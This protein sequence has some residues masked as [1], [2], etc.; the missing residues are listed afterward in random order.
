MNIERYQL[1][2]ETEKS[3]DQL[4]D[5]VIFVE[6]LIEECLEQIDGDIPNN[7]VIPILIHRHLLQKTDSIHANIDVGTED[8]A[9]AIMRTLIENF[10]YLSYILHSDTDEK[11]RAYYL[12]WYKSQKTELQKFKPDHRKS[13]VIKTFI[14][15]DFEEQFPNEKVQY[16]ID[17]IEKKI[18]ASWL[19]NINKK[20]NKTQK[21]SRKPFIAWHSLFGHDSIR[22]VAVSVG[23]EAEYETL[24]SI[25]SKETHSMNAIQL[26]ENRDGR[27]YFKPLRTYE[28]PKTIVN[29]ATNYLWKATDLILENLFPD[30]RLAFLIYSMHNQESINVIQHQLKLLEISNQEVLEVANKMIIKIRKRYDSSLI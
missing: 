28:D 5:M 8:A 3:L 22:Q 27:S 24:Y 19:K 12:S 6:N 11:S 13:P 16:E 23:L 10:I 4:G 26:L 2:V 1:N 14:G 20:W 21:K 30:K 15:E 29:M 7:I 9:K 17:L 18:N 25:Y